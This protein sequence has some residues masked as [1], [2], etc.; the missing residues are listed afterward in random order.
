MYQQCTTLWNL[1]SPAEKKEWDT[2]ARPKHMPPYAMFMSCC[3]KP[4]PGVYLPLAGGTM[5]GPI[6]MT[7]NKITGLGDPTS[8]QD[9]ATRLFTLAQ[10]ALHAALT[11]THGIAGTIAGLADIATHAALTATHGIAGTIAGLADIATHAALTATHG[12]AGTIAG[13]A[14]IATHAALTATHGITGTIASVANIATHA[15]LTATHGVAGTIAGLADITTHAALTATHEAT[16]IAGITSGSYPGNN[17]VN[18]ELP[19]GLGKL[20]KIIIITTYLDATNAGILLITYPTPWAIRYVSDTA[21]SVLIVAGATSTNFYVG[22][23]TNYH[24][25]ANALYYGYDWIAIA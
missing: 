24:Q 18:R 3:L 15:A 20:P 22:N 7:T 14:D 2:L 25:S 6:A 13:L 23:A 19:H 8:P 1:L 4:N 9:A 5:S 21:S 16:A 11:A 12:V 17:A 10:I